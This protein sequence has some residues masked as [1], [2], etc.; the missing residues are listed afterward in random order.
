MYVD[1]RLA[2]MNISQNRKKV[3]DLPRTRGERARSLN[4]DEV[5]GFTSRGSTNLRAQCKLH[6]RRSWKAFKI[7]PS[8]EVT[9]QVYRFEIFI[10]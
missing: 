2:R 7:N 6:F 8:R 10:R 1:S 5:R 4:E 9:V 3:R